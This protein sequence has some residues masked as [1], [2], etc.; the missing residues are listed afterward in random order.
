MLAAVTQSLYRNT[1]KLVV[2]VALVV[3][4]LSCEILQMLIL[5]KGTFVP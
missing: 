2:G 3:R 4:F 1:G 5:L